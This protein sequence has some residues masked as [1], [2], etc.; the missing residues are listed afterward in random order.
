M[1]RVPKKQQSRQQRERESRATRIRSRQGPG[2]TAANAPAFSIR[3]CCSAR[4]PVHIYLAVLTNE[5]RRDF[6][7]SL[8][9]FFFSL[10]LETKPFSLL[11]QSSKT[12]SILFF[13]G[14]QLSFFF[15]SKIHVTKLQ[16]QVH[17]LKTREICL[18]FYKC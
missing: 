10:T 9:A 8:L 18:M 3:Q 1:M 5:R 17:L 6:F 15:P 13:F 4:T 7:L 2:Q 14:S 12:A 16:T 11:T